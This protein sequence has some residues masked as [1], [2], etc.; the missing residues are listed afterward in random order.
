MWIYVQ[1]EGK[2]YTLPTRFGTFFSYFE[3]FKSY[4]GLNVINKVWIVKVLS[5]FN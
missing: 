1:F 4:G 2:L 5:N 3:S